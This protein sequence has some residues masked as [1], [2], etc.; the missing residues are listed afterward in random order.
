[1]SNPYIQNVLFAETNRSSTSDGK[2][3]L[4]AVSITTSNGEA[5]ELGFQREPETLAGC[6]QQEDG[7]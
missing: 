4:A 5:V 6:L 3:A 1:M 7:Q 2:N